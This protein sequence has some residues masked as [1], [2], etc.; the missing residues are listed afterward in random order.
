MLINYG[1]K[2]LGLPELRVENWQILESGHRFQVVKENSWAICPF[3]GK[4]TTR[5]HDRRLQSV[6]DLPIQNRPTTLKL[7]KR[8][9]RC[10]SCLR[11]FSETYNNLRP[12]SRKT[13]RFEELLFHQSRNPFQWVAQE[14]PM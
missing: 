5:I 7:L 4:T 12:Y 6:R 1:T 9:F 13:T 10:N 14:A 11:V 2:L 3:C 8:R